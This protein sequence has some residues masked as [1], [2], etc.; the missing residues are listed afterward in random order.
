MD[1]LKLA[2]G[3]LG[4]LVFIRNQIERNLSIQMEWTAIVEKG[5]GALSRLEQACGE[6]DPIVNPV[7]NTIL[8]YVRP[9]HSIKPY[10]T[11]KDLTT[12]DHV[13]DNMRQLA[14]MEKGNEKEARDFSKHVQTFLKN[15]TQENWI[16]LYMYENSAAES[17][18]TGNLRA[19]IDGIGQFAP[20]EDSMKD[21]Q[22]YAKKLDRSLNEDKAA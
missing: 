17:Q 14:P 11:K 10:P 6:N 15:P 21:L 18:L 19:I 7:A 4:N 22:K 13:I 8:G 3:L 16:S 1:I 9:L 12:L 2:R 20:E 5:T